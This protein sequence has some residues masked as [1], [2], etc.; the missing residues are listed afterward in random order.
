MISTSKTTPTA[1]EKTLDRALENTFPASD[2]VAIEAPVHPSERP[3]V[4][5]KGQARQGVTGLNV[6]S[7]LTL[8]LAGAIAALIIVYIYYY[9]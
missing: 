3:V 9:A 4:E 2:P 7:V 8:G 1:A 6:R 5:P